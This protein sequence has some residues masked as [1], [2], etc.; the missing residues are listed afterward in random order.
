[1]NMYIQFFNQKVQKMLVK[2]NGTIF[3]VLL[4]YK[5]LMNAR[6]QNTSRMIVSH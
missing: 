2:N 6:F 4:K 3:N 5:L 1:M